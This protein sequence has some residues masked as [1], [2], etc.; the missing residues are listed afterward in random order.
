MAILENGSFRKAVPAALAILPARSRKSDRVS[1]ST[2]QREPVQQPAADPLSSTTEAPDLAALTSAVER[3]KMAAL[4]AARP[5][6]VA[7]QRQRGK[8]TARERIDRLVDS[9]SF[10]ELGRLARP[11]ESE[12][13]MADVDAPADGVVVG[14]G[15]VCG[16]QVAVVAYDFT[17]LGGSMGSI[18][19]EKFTAARHLSLRAGIPLVMLLEGGGA[20]V[21][22]RMG[23]T[24]LRGHERF[25]ELSLLSGWAPIVSAVMGPTFAG[26]ANLVA[27]SD[28]TV[29]VK[30]ASLGLAGPKIVEAA[31]GERSSPEELG[32]TKLHARE[33]GSVELDVDDEDQA[34]DALK[35]YLSLMPSNAREAAPREPYDSSSD[36]KLPDSVMSLIPS[37]PNAPYD[38]RQLVRLLLDE[39]SGLESK[40]RFAANLLTTFGRL[41]GYSVG[42][43]ANNSVFRAGV[44]DA[45]ASD[46]MARFINVC[47]AFGLPVV[48]LVD[49]PGFLVGSAAE[50]TNI[51][52]HS[53][54]PLWELGQST[55]PILTVVV[56]KAYGLG[57]HAMGASE[58]HP[59]LLVCW[60]SALASPMGAEG[61]VKVIYGKT[62]SENQIR[63][64]TDQFKRMEP[65][66]AAAESFKVEDIIDP[67]DTRA[68]LLEQLRFL[69]G[70]QYDLGRWRPRK[71]RGVS[72]V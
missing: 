1:W 10:V 24:T 23:S 45:S 56:R 33:L 41:G 43:I 66:L 15:S 30:G 46:K 69:D 36:E 8:L 17:V 19:D 55:V 68:V 65:P 28:F 11:K 39:G 63:E 40:P 49:V 38:M 62:K 51:L 4:D 50:R 67:R 2:M 53:M 32:G 26:H 70:R 31:I 64:L 52:R 14:R 72:P 35:Q 37:K 6:A 29:M 25:S 7:R 20:R 27:L 71:K 18:N 42:V 48:M 58:F 13:L 57:F 54:R 59:A 61:A 60:P 22:E 16:R 9:G 21:N 12:G 34:I 5:E 3:R 47:D 44:L